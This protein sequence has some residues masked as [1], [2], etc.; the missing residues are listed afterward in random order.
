MSGAVQLDPIIASI[1]RTQK[2]IYV[3]SGINIMLILIFS[4]ILCL[5]RNACHNSL[6]IDIPP[7]I[8]HSFLPILLLILILTIISYES[9]EFIHINFLGPLRALMILSSIVFILY[10]VSEFIAGLIL[11]STDRSKTYNQLTPLGKSYYNNSLD[12]LNSAYRINI[13]IACLFQIISSVIL[14]ACGIT[15]WILHSK[16]PV[17]YLPRPKYA[18][19]AREV[20]ND[21]KENK[22]YEPQLR[23]D[24]SFNQE[25]SKLNQSE[26]DQ[27]IE[28]IRED[29]ADHALAP[30]RNPFLRNS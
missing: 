15:V 7:Y 8:S 13:V 29:E 3:M 12:N 27:K 19:V 18:I 30:P 5:F 24:N 1:E 25:E 22:P 11:S 28:V 16:T 21:P 2:A 17:G 6:D 26:F 20:P 10:T 23:N 4:P 9:T 14:L